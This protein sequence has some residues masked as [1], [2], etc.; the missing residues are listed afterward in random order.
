MSTLVHNDGPRTGIIFQI[1]KEKTKRSM[2]TCCLPNVQFYGEKKIW[3]NYLRFIILEDG[4]HNLEHV[5]LDGQ[6]L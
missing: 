5:G 3:D 2:R 4:G 6:Q 1:L